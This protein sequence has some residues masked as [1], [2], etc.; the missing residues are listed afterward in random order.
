MTISEK[1]V[2]MVENSTKIVENAPAI[3]RQAEWSDFWDAYQDYGNRKNYGG[4]FDQSGWNDKTFK[5]KYDIIPDTYGVQMF[6]TSGITDLKKILEDAGVKLDLSKCDSLLQMFQSS[7]ITHLPIIDGSVATSYY[8][9]FESA[10]QLISID[11]FIV[12][13][14]ATTFGSCFRQCKNLESVIFEGIIGKDL[15]FS[16]CVLLNKKS[17]MSIIFAL[18]I[19]MGR[20][21]TTV[22]FS[23]TAV[24]KAFETSEGAN[25]GADSEYFNNIAATARTANWNIVFV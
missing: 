17:I 23:L 19:T 21:E 9:T 18:D 3:G 12:N 10:R 13:E 4:A 22:T 16:D 25:D 11:K 24:N 2:E 20:A 14:N 1:I 6:H 8:Y 5:P 7:S 15:S